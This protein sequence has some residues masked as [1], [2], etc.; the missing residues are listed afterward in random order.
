[1]SFATEPGY[2]PIWS[3]TL[4][5][6]N[7]ITAQTV[8]T[9]IPS[10]FNV[11]YQKPNIVGVTIAN[12]GT[13]VFTITILGS[14]FCDRVKHKCANLFLCGDG[15]NVAACDLSSSAAN[16]INQIDNAHIDSWTHDRIVA[17]VGV[18]VDWL[19]IQPSGSSLSSSKS[20]P[21]FFSTAAYNIQAGGDFK[22]NAAGTD[23]EYANP[24][25]TA[26]DLGTKLK[27]HVINLE[28]ADN[29]VVKVNNVPKSVL[30]SDCTEVVPGATPKLW[31][32][33]FFAPEGSGFKQTLKVSKNTKE[34]I[35]SAFIYY[36]KPII[37]DVLMPATN[38]VGECSA[39]TSSCPSIEATPGILPTKGQDVIIRGSNFGTKNSPNP[40]L[41]R[42][43][44]NSADI[45]GLVSILSTN[46]QSGACTE[47]T[48]TSIKCTLPP[49]QGQGYTLYV[50][51]AAQTPTNGAWPGSARS[52]A[53]APPTVTNLAPS[54]GPTLTPGTITVNGKNF[55]FIQPSMKIEGK[56]CAVQLQ[57]NG[58]H[59]SFQC[60]VQDGEGV[61]LPAIVTAGGQHS[62][63][64][65]P[66]FSYN[67]SR[68]IEQNNCF[69]I[70]LFVFLDVVYYVFLNF[71]F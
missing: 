59:T 49:S 3:L 61:N 17:R 45:P 7:S 6:T 64:T 25:S 4:I 9:E 60:I 40:F 27:I 42:W 2:G 5:V 11:G 31:Q 16:T 47:H 10:K 56:A 1:M 51:I 21:A 8:Y 30:P 46:A 50:E 28:N 68:Q 67:V 41:F 58:Y 22:M 44:S 55:G 70:S 63:S 53:Y 39:A 62:S 32:I 18:S 54:N 29:I 20:N 24:I 19:F 23:L 13:S 43:Q 12:T 36:A 65:G 66:T 57:T 33:Q 69:T 35:N 38:F 52:I 14:N 37:T 71:S 34:T 26:G 15:D 48:H